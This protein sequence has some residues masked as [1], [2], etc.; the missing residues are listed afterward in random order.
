MSRAYMYTILKN[1]KAVFTSKI[2]QL[3]E[4]LDVSTATIKKY[5]DESKILKGCEIIQEDGYYPLPEKVKKPQKIPVELLAEWDR[6][7][8]AINPKAKR[9]VC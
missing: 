2:G 1:D 5:C 3:A 7:R 6:V 9:G 8:L 4:Y